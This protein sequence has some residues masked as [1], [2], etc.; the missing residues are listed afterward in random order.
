[1]GGEVT[2]SSSLSRSVQ[3]ASFGCSPAAD[4]AN[5]CWVAPGPR[6]AI[7]RPV[8]WDQIIGLMLALLLMGAGTVGCLLPSFPGS[9]L[10]LGGAVLHRF[11]FGEASVGNLVLVLLVLLTCFALA[12]DYLASVYGAKRFGATRWGVA[13]A[14]VGALGG[15]FWP[16]PGLLVGP[17][18]GATV[19][20]MIA[21]REWRESARAGLGATLGFLAGGVGKFAV[22]VGMTALFTFNVLQRSW[23]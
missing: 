9:P 12:L 7:L 22:A 2:E 21:G 5:G 23:S 8:T 15:M 4:P 20:E 18:V 3:Q 13:G 17:F 11:Y 16:L 10:V 19:L 1:M 14:L 6:C